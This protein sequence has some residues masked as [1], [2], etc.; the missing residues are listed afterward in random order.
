M[1][2]SALRTAQCRGVWPSSILLFLSAPASN[3][4][5]ATS[6]EPLPAAVCNGVWSRTIALL[7]SA[8][9]SSN[10]CATSNCHL[11]AAR[12]RAVAPSDVLLFVSAAS[13]SSFRTSGCPLK[14]A[15][16]KALQPSSV[17][18]ISRSAPDSNNSSTVCN[19][20][21]PPLPQSVVLSSHHYL[22]ISLVSGSCGR[23]SISTTCST[24]FCTHAE[25]SLA[26]SCST[27][28][29][30]S[31][32]T[33]CNSSGGYI[34][35]LS[36]SSPALPCRIR[37]LNLETPSWWE[38]YFFS[39]RMDLPFRIISSISSNFSASRTATSVPA[40]AEDTCSKKNSSQGKDCHE[41][42]W[43]SGNMRKTSPG[44]W[45]DSINTK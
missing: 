6:K 17:A 9:A 27:D 7:F 45:F 31:R 16:C 44:W 11:A 34:S 24:S 40:D 35:C 21:S 1:S 36:Q 29:Q 12:C 5:R 20:G 13:R 28:G 26:S 38:R 22:L 32:I 43:A 2:R 3:N 30:K 23:W 18:A 15:L 4:N 19:L 37:C 33:S 42:T 39:P 10:N 8:P 25:M 14:A 41:T